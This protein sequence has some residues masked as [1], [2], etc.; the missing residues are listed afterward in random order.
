M[1]KNKRFWNWSINLQ[2]ILCR[3]K[4][5]KKARSRLLQLKVSSLLNLLMP[6]NLLKNRHLQALL[7]TRKKKWRGRR[8]STGTVWLNS[9][10]MMRKN[11]LWFKKAVSRS[12]KSRWVKKNEQNSFNQSRLKV[13]VS[14]ILSRNH[15]FQ[16]LTSHRSKLQI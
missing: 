13:K 4:L 7:S 8:K 3:L 12:R 6:P 1:K 15:N 11:N 9:H 14:R 5:S 10:K 2:I 16:L